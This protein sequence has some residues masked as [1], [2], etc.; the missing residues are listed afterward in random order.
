MCHARLLRTHLLHRHLRPL[1]PQHRNQP[2]ILPRLHHK[3]R[4]RLRPHGTLP[5]R[6]RRHPHQTHLHPNSLRRSSSSSHVHLD[7][8]NK[9]SRIHRLGMLLGFRERGA[10]HS[11]DVHRRSQ[12]ILSR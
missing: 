7:R 9:N 6:L 4:L 3:R 2:L 12:G 10:S 1:R 5:P 11:A 8:D